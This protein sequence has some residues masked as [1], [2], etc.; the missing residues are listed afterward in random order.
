MNMAEI[1]K[2]FADEVSV[3]DLVVC[4]AG[5]ILFT[6]WLLKTSLGRNAL[7]D[8][9]PRRN[10][11][12]PYTPFVPILLWLGTTW[13]ALS[14]KEHLL[15]KL[16]DWRNI[17]ADNLI[18]CLGVVP[19]TA[20]IIILAQN[21]F[22]RRLRGFGLD[23]RTIH[24]DFAAAT[25]N[26]LTILPFVLAMIAVTILAGKLIFGPDFEMRQHEELVQIAEYP[27]MPLKALIVI[28]TILVV[29]A[30]EEILF[31]G[32]FQTMVR[33]FLEIRNPGPAI[34]NAAWPAIVFT[35]VIFASFHANPQHWPALFVLSLCLGYS[36]EKSGSLLRPIFI[37]S[38]FNAVSVASALAQ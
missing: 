13:L 30:F 29:P 28:I 2:Q 17:F 21:T 18:I 12:L 20:A 23:V 16:P 33:S 26:L 3:I 14:A 24:K 19:A 32:L 31:R 22:A 27:E 37:H 5:L 8:S 25:V 36:Y 9:P 6:R 4:A 15:G 35:S 11:M 7:S 1:I 34:R 38:L 10:N